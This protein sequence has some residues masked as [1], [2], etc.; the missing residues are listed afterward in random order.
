MPQSI[1]NDLSD[2]EFEDIVA[3]SL[4]ITEVTKKCGFKACK[5]GG[6]RERVVK[7]IR[8]LKCDIS[9]FRSTGRQYEKHPRNKIID[10]RD[11]LRKG[12]ISSRVTIREVVLREKLVEYK[13]CICG[14]DGFWNG[15][16][17]SLQLHHK[18]GDHTNNEVENLSFLCPNCH[19]QTENYGGKKNVRERKKYYCTECGQEITKDT[20]TGRCKACAA[21]LSTI[22]KPEKEE[23]IRTIREI[24]FKKYVCHHYGVCEHTLNK[25]LYEY[26]LPT[27]ISE[28]H[29]YLQCEEV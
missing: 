28:L 24:K 9:H 2:D 25:W 19:S 29:E 1:L 14:N 23:L 22:Q 18:D 4:S 13:C 26:R 6:G 16:P 3:S 17:L 11:V 20:R 5:G 15:N 7:R 12:S 21:K 10:Y 27:H 8:N